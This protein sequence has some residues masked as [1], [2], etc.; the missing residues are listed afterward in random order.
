MKKILLTA[1][2]CVC[3]SGGYATQLLATTVN[4]TVEGEYT[5]ELFSVQLYANIQVDSEGELLSA[6]VKI[7]Y[8]PSQWFTPLVATKNETLWFIGTE[9]NKFPYMSPDTSTDGEIIFLLGR[10]DSDAP[11]EGIAGSRVLLGTSEFQ[12]K[13]GSDSPSILDVQV[14]YE[15]FEN[16]VTVNGISLGT[17]VTFETSGFTDNSDGMDNTWELLYFGN[18]SHTGS[19]DSDN[20]GYSNLQEFLNAQ[21]YVRDP[22]DQVFNPVVANAPG[23]VGYE[24]PDNSAALIPILFLLMEKADAQ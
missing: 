11:L 17:K 16:F 7:N 22:E 12:R 3:I 10:L 4:V 9:I 14:A 5:D 18:L 8:D 2:L 23:G 6:G 20:D 1:F 19:E 13:G 21:A 15:D 24:K